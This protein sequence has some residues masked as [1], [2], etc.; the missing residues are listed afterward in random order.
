LNADVGFGDPFEPVFGFDPFVFGEVVETIRMPLFGQS[1]VSP[2]GIF[3]G[4]SGFQI[5]DPVI[6]ERGGL[7]GCR[8]DRHRP[9]ER[10]SGMIF[11]A[12]DRL[13]EPVEL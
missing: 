1:P 4:G 11:P 9:P 2:L 13:D 8:S 5:E 6:F 7:L 3:P 12:V 10:L